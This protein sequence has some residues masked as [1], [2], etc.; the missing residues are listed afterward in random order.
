MESFDEVM[1]ARLPALSRYAAVLTGDRDLAQ[2]VVQDALISGANRRR[3][4][5][6]VAALPLA[7]VIFVGFALAGRF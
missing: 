6:L 5:A 1:A 4:L 7:L 2:D 3:A